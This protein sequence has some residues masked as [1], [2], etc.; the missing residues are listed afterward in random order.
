MAI[1]LVA[2]SNQ[3]NDAL[4]VVYNTS[5]DVPLYHWT[6]TDT[7]FYPIYID[8]EPNMKNPIRQDKD[9][10]LRISLRHTPGFPLSQVPA[11]F[12]LQKADTVMEHYILPK[13][14]LQRPVA[15]NVRDERGMPLG[16]G[17]GSLYEYQ[18]IIPDIIV[19]FPEPGPY[20]MLIIPRFDGAE[21]GIDGMASIGIELYE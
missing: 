4:T 21:E 13:R 5:V 6:S 20:R 10:H 15:P 12:C 8:K 2:C 16:T 3:S 18:E 11:Y 1:S 7:L 17:W 14:I 19:R 9:Y